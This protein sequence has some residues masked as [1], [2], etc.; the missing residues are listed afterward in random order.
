M[1]NPYL[2][3]QQLL[4]VLRPQYSAG[5]ARAIALLVLEEA[6]GWSQTDVYIGKSKP[7][8]ADRQTALLQIIHRLS[9][10]EPVQY[11]LGKAWFLGRRYAVRPGVL[12]PRPETEDLVEWVVEDHLSRPR[13]RILDC[14]TGTGC[15]AISLKLALPEAHVEACDISQTALEVA[16][17]NA[18]ALSADVR[19]IHRDMGSLGM[20]EPYDLI[21]SNP[22]YVCLSEREGMAA[23]VTRHEP[24][25]ALY[26]SDSDPLIHYRQ[27]AQTRLPLYLEINAALADATIEMLQSQGYENP[28]LKHDRYGRPRMIKAS[29]NKHI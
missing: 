10:G 28:I 19:F 12:I 14:G 3:F 18:Q 17:E 1:E 5:E 13:M 15:I 2:I 4:S 24:P 21:V 23:H 16:E 27:M 6:F 22:P 7:F 8:S 9:Q 11:V 26:V 20:S 29:C 25:E